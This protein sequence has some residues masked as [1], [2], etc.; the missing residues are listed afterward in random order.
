MACYDTSDAERVYLYDTD[1]D[2]TPTQSP[3]VTPTQS[4]IMGR[5][6]RSTIKESESPEASASVEKSSVSCY[7][8]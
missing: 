7:K 6:S 8:K 4:P 3:D 5:K 2:V 1:N